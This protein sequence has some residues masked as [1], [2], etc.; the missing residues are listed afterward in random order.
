MRYWLTRRNSP[1][2][3][4]SKWGRVRKGCSSDNYYVFAIAK[5]RDDNGNDKSAVQRVDRKFNA[6]RCVAYRRLEAWPEGRGR[7]ILK[8]LRHRGFRTVY[9]GGQIVEDFVYDHP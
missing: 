6:N 2:K 7:R 4:S 3:W 5:R 8:A 9:P 1:P